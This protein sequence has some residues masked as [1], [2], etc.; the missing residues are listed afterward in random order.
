MNVREYTCYN[1]RSVCRAKSVFMYRKTRFSLSVDEDEQ[2]DAEQDGR[3]RLARQNSQARTGTG[4]NSCFLVQLTT[5]RVGNH[6][7]LI[8]TLLK[9]LTIHTC[10]CPYHGCISK[11]TVFTVYVLYQQTSNPPTVQHAHQRCVVVA[12]QERLRTLT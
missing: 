4:K 9:V 7:R 6:T 1:I 11:N 2:A 10:I 12:V 5:S 3:T 8:H